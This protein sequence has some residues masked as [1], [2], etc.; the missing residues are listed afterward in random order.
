MTSTPIVD[1]NVWVAAYD[2]TDR[3]HADSAAFLY[4]LANL[5]IAARAPAILV[6]EVACALARR[7]GDT[8]VGRGAA[9]KLEEHTLL[10]MEPLDGRLLS[11]AV[12]LGTANGLRAADALYAATAAVTRGGVLVSWDLELI[13]R[14]GA[15][16]PPVWLSTQGTG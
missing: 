11:E 13:E 12:R 15:V 2:A 6:L 14:A 5:G 7:F 9:A 8:S 10:R 3:F 4:T 16:T 1:A